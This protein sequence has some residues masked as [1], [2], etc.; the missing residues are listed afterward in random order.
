MRP[1]NKMAF[2]Y[3]RFKFP[4]RS[5]VIES[6]GS[7]EGMHVYGNILCHT[8]ILALWPR[9]RTIINYLV[10]SCFF[11]GERR[12]E[13]PHLF[14]T[15]HCAGIQWLWPPFILQFRGDG[16]LVSRPAVLT[17]TSSH[18]SHTTDM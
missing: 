17:L 14:C 7:L 15:K 9:Y 12:E 18:F 13:N 1:A 4:L 3:S 8:Q 2:G 5:V 11:D 16:N 6:Y 10:N